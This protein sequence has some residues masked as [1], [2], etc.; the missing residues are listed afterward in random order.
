[1]SCCAD[2]P[3]SVACDRNAGPILEVLETEFR[4]ARDVLEIGS[5]TGQHAVRFA[6]ALRHLAWQTSDLEQ[7]HPGIRAWLDDAG[8]PNAIQPLALDVVTADLP[9]Q[10]YSAVFSANTAHIMGEHAVAAMFALVGK[11]LVPGGAFC[12]YGPFR[13]GGRFSSPSN[14]D[15]DASLRRQDPRMG[16]RDIEMLDALAAQNGLCRKA[17]YAMPANNEVLVWEQSTRQLSPTS[18]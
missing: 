6:G 16:I 7:N 17:R 12:L 18:D 10:S 4:S 1:M 11:V 13:E 8:L 3:F 2:K 15:F 14:A 9:A 5:G